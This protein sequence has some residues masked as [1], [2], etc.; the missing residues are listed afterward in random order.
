MK[1]NVKTVSLMQESLIKQTKHLQHGDKKGSYTLHNKVDTVIKDMKKK[2]TEDDNV[3][4]DVL[5]LLGEDGLKIMTQLINSI[6][7]I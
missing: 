5:K 7:E 1:R 2:A 4:G 6:H 3:P